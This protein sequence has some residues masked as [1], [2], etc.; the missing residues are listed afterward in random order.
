VAIAEAPRAK[1]EIVRR[2]AK[3]PRLRLGL[4]WG[5]PEKPRPT[6]RARRT[7]RAGSTRPGYR[8]RPS[9]TSHARVRD[10]ADGV[11]R[12]ACGGRAVG[13]G[14]GSRN[15]SA[16]MCGSVFGRG[17]CACAPT[18]RTSSRTTR[19]PPATSSTCSQSAGRSSR[20]SPTAA[21]TTWRAFRSVGDEARV[22]RLRHGRALHTARRRAG[23]GCQPLDARV[24]G[25]RLRRGDRGRP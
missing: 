14:T 4:Y 15:D 17:A 20:A 13:T 21:T 18:R 3:R 1:D 23:R 7:R 8:S 6:R 5:W 11:F 24:H 22:G 25:R 19:V 2:L 10:D 9:S 12:P 16:G